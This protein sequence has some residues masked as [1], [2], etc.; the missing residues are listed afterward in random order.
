MT[1]AMW[2]KAVKNVPMDLLFHLKKRQELESKIAS[3][4]QK[5]T[6]ACI[7]VLNAIRL[8]TTYGLLTK[9]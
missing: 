9:S 3:P 5:V 1:S 6:N 7:C 4:A 2:P 8:L